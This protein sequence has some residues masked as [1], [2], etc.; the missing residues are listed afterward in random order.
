MVSVMVAM[1]AGIAGSVM[2]SVMGA[3]RTCLVVMVCLMVYALAVLLSM[4]SMVAHLIG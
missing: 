1:M 2:V 3:W 4:A